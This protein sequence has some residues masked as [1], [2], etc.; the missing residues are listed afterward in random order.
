M[1]IGN[2]DTIA[3]RE[4]EK[5]DWELSYS[6]R[7]G[8]RLRSSSSGPRDS[9]KTMLLTRFRFAKRAPRRRAAWTVGAGICWARNIDTI[10][11]SA[12]SNRMNTNFG[13]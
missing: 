3:E 2:A 4:H 1:R 5:I 13:Y 11:F 12:F 7:L 8:K 10:F 9:S 6:P